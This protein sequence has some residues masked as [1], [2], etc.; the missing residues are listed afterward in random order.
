MP[1]YRCTTPPELLND[2]QR[3]AIA[4][5]I[6]RIHC[7]LTQA[8]PTFVHVQFLHAA[9]AEGPRVRVH[10]SIRAGR[11]AALNEELIRQCRH[12]VSA[13]AGVPLED[14]AMRTST[15]QAAWVLEGGHV[16]PEPGE[17]AAWLAE[18]GERTHHA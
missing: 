3:T 18:L 14:T 2:A 8:P 10:G 11:S 16:M 9:P 17:E 7:E 12:S 1:L 13:L 15:T 4:G 6:T 5:A